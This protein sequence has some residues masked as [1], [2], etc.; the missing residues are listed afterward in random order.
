MD[1]AKFS[2]GFRTVPSASLN[3]ALRVTRNSQEFL[4]RGGDRLSAVMIPPRIKHP[5][6]DKQLN[7]VGTDLDANP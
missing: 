4:D 6:R 2:D 1:T 3:S 5:R 7:I